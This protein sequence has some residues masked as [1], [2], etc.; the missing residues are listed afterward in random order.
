MP[1]L[2]KQKQSPS[3]P[4]ENQISLQSLTTPVMLHSVFTQ[5]NVLKDKRELIL[6]PGTPSHC[7]SQTWLYHCTEVWQQWQRDNQCC[8]VQAVVCC[9]PLPLLFRGQ[10]WV[11]THQFLFYNLFIIVS[12]RQNSDFTLSR[13]PEQNVILGNWSLYPYW[14]PSHR[15]ANELNNRRKG[16]FGTLN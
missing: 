15:L 16:L 5:E 7:C 12:G 2:T 9:W 14:N 4:I 1:L 11:S 8:R 13:D 10:D 3:K 6:R